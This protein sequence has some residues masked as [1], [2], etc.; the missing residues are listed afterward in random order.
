[1]RNKRMFNVSITG[2]SRFLMMPH[3]SQLLYFHLGMHADDDGYCEHFM[4]MKMLGSSPDD[5][6]ILHAKDFICIF[7]DHVLLILNWR[8]NNYI[9]KDRYVKSKYLEMHKKPL[10]STNC[11]PEKN[12][13]STNCQPTDIMPRTKKLDVNQLSTNSQ[14]LDN[15]EENR[16]EENSKKKYKKK[17]CRFLP[18]SFLEIQGYCNERKN[19]ID[20][21]HFYDFYESKGWMIGSNKMK[22]WQA[23]I[24]TWEKMNFS[25]NNFK[26]NSDELTPWQQ[27]QMR[28]QKEYLDEQNASQ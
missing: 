27:E 16:R 3:S 14:P 11:Q 19:N 2:S 18:P 22:N 9:R 8:E 20:P 15:I 21:Q 5:L 7:D 26:N 28:K 17:N 10:I 4:V 23:A 12:Q 24:R 13:L 25:S 1:M 6:K